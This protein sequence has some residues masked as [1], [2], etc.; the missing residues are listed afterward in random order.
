[1]IMNIL[2]IFLILIVKTIQEEKILFAFQMNNNGARSPNYGV[3]NEIDFFKEKWYG[4][5]EL[6][7]IGKRQL[8]LSGIKA[9]KRYIN[10]LI[11]E[12]YNPQDILIKSTD[13]NHTIESIY[14]FLQGLYQYGQNISNININKKEI[15]YPPNKKYKEHFDKILKEYNMENNINAL[16]YGISIQPIHIFY[17]PNNDFQL[18]NENKCK[19][20]N[21]IIEQYNKRIEIKEF[22][23]NLSDDVKDMFKK[24]ENSPNID[25]LYNYNN[26]YKYSDS[27]VCDYFDVRNFDNLKKDL[28]I[29]NNFENLLNELNIISNDFLSKDY[30]LKYNLSEINIVDSSQTLKDIIYWMDQTINNIKNNSNKYLKY[31]IYSSDDSSKGT[32][33]GFISKLFNKNIN[34]S[35]FSESINIELYSEQNDKYKV[36]YLKGYNDI[37]LD[38]DYYDFRKQ[39]ENTIWNKEKINEFCN[40]EIENKK[41]IDKTDKKNK[42]NKFGASV[43]II[44]SII[45]GFLIAFLILICVKK[46]I[47]NKKIGAEVTT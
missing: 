10:K 11:Q 25:F 23:N 12:T 3:N 17:K 46:N 26:L 37:I 43:I 1:M 31:V 18:L 19:G 21:E 30:I 38:I 2:K 33:E 16:P 41:D 20:I 8:Y 44:L 5:N 6:S 13:Y 36:R 40:F 27:F 28:I 34:Y 35:N 47:K 45:D 29:E 42:I 7:I 22:V 24:L 39:I 4:N 32:L 9:R 14:S 15:I